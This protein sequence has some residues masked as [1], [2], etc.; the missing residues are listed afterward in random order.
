VVPRVLIGAAGDGG[1]NLI[2]GLLAMLLSD[3][4]G[5]W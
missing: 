1:G 5:M 2:Q 3:R 4:L